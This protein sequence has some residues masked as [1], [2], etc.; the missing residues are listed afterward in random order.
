MPIFYYLQSNDYPRFL[1]SSLLLTV[2]LI[3][4]INMLGMHVNNTKK[5]T[6]TAGQ[7]L[8]GARM[9]SANSPRSHAGLTCEAHRLCN[10]RQD[11]N[12]YSNHSAVTNRQQQQISAPSLSACS[13][14]RQITRVS[15]V[16]TD[17]H[18][19]LDDD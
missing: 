9:C 19:I 16:K 11:E 17:L 15:T 5:I 4:Q 3:C 6:R 7:T 12:K 2:Y 1:D 18:T 8:V 13:N 10:Y 14:P